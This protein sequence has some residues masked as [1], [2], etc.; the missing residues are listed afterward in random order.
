MT[1]RVLT[2]FLL[3]A[4]LI[5]APAAAIERPTDSDQR[6]LLTRL[7]SPIFGLLGLGRTPEPASGPAAKIGLTVE[8]GGG[9]PPAGSTSSSGV[10]MTVEPGGG[11][12]GS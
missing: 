4:C 11:G 7:V 2:V 9:D 6:P 12:S 1:N 3:T 5:A 8:P 10:G